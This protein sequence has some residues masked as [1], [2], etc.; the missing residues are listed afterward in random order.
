MHPPH[1]Y[2]IAVE[3]DV[4]GLLAGSSSLAPL[5]AA[6]CERVCR[7][8]P[9]RPGFALLDFGATFT[10]LL[11]RTFLIAFVEALDRAYLHRFARRL[12][13]LTIGRFDQQVSTGAHRDGGPDESVLLLGY[14]PTEVNSRM[15]LLDHTRRAA[16]LGLTPAEFLE[17]FNPAFG[18][19][20][21]ELR[22]C[23]TEL[24]EFGADRYRALVVNNSNLPENQGRHGM[25]G[26]LHRAVIATP[27][28]GKSRIINSLLLAATDQ[29]TEGFTGGE[30]AAF[31]ADGTA[32]AR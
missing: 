27:R 6:V 8:N 20:L 30:L 32:A 16:E 26:V 19:G 22:D 28:P 2:Q 3:V 11:F 29:A 25:L 9:S 17:R 18:T 23:T 14:E 24:A 5:A 4:P 10:P 21:H 12:Q 15:Q 7:T 1:A 13:P 31:A